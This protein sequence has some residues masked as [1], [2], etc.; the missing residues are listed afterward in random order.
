M[1]STSLD[2]VLSLLFRHGLT[3]ACGALITSGYVPGTITKDQMIGAGMGV[4]AIALSWWNKR[5]YA[6][7]MGHLKDFEDKI[8]IHGLAA[9][10]QAPGYGAA[11]VDAQK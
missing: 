11:H 5:G 1:D 3:V 2:T 9:N 6:L 10:Y 4:G 7:A 8:G